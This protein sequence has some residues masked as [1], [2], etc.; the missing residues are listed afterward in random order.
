MAFFFLKSRAARKSVLGVYASLDS[1]KL[2]Q[3]QLQILARILILR[4]IRFT[5]LP[6]RQRICTVFLCP[7]CLIPGFLATRML[8]TGLATGTHFIAFPFFFRFEA[9]LIYGH[10]GE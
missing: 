3:V 8:K 7:C 9:Y 10:S 5:I 2:A 4:L 6:I 1:K